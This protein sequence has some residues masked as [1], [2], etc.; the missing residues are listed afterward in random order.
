MFQIDKLPKWDLLPASIIIHTSIQGPSVD[1][2]LSVQNLEFHINQCAD[3]RQVSL[4]GAPMTPS[5]IWVHGE[6]HV[7]QENIKAHYPDLFILGSNS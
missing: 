5:D 4:P 3:V 1:R 2:I 7:F 6:P